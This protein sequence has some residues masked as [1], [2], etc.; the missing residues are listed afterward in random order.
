[1]KLQIDKLDNCPKCGTRWKGD[2]IFLYYLAQA[3]IPGNYYSG[4]T[5][6]EVLEIAAEHGYT[7]ENPQYFCNLIGIEIRGE[8]DGISRWM[9][10]GCKAQ[11]CRWTN[12]ELK[13]KG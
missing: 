9:C 8:Y 12:K 7:I 10:P 1:M 6:D 11:W 3:K 4:K 13:N 2:D 5:R